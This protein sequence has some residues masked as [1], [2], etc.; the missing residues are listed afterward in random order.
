MCPCVRASVRLCVRAFVRILGI[1]SLD[2][3]DFLHVVRDPQWGWRNTAQFFFKAHFGKNGQEW[4]QNNVF[5]IFQKNESLLLAGNSIKWKNA[6]FSI[7]LPRPVRENSGSRIMG[8]KGFGTV[9]KRIFCLFFKIESLDLAWVGLKWTQ[10]KL[11]DFYILR[12]LH[13]K[14]IVLSLK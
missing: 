13:A 3:S 2:F 4:T 5:W 14:V 6:F 7:I 9:R 10:M 11:M 8:P 1:G 12:K